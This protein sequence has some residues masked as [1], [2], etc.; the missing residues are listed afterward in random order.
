MKKIIQSLSFLLIILFCFIVISLVINKSLITK[1]KMNFVSP[2]IVLASLRSNKSVILVNVL[3]DKIPFNLDC[4]NSINNKSFT[5]KEFEN[6]LSYNNNSLKNIDLVILYCASWS[7]S[8]AKKYYE[9]L[10]NRGLNMNKIYDYK[11]AIHE[12]SSYSLLFPETYKMK[13]I[14][15]NN[16]A[17]NK[18]LIKLVNDTKHTYLLK[19]EK[20]SKHK[21]IKSLSSNIFTF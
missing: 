1:S 16:T 3:G 7:C 13:N 10:E 8:A 20:N 15:T 17:N 6:Y 14:I 18:E 21:I 19:D 9:Q 12:W 5:K 11:G 2:Y 4:E